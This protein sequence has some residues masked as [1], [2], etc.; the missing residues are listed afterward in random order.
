MPTLS[1]FCQVPAT[2]LLVALLLASGGIGGGP[3]VAQDSATS[4]P[5]AGA[6]EERPEVLARSRDW[7]IRRVAATQ[8]NPAKARERRALLRLL[9]EDEDSGVRIAALERLADPDIA[10]E[11]ALVERAAAVRLAAA[12]LMDRESDLM[13]LFGRETDPEVKGAIIGR[14]ATADTLATIYGRE[15][16]ARVRRAALERLLDLGLLNEALVRTVVRSD[17]DSEVRRWMLGHLRDP[18]LILETAL[19]DERAAVRERAVTRL[20]ETAPTP[21]RAIDQALEDISE[22][23][24]DPAVRVVALRALPEANDRLLEVVA[25]SHDERLRALIVPH[26]VDLDL[27][28]QLA[29]RDPAASVRRAALARVKDREVLLAAA[30]GDPDAAARRVAVR[31]L[32][33]DTDRA[34]VARRTGDLGVRTEAVSAITSEAVLEALALPEHYWHL[35]M[36]AATRITSPTVL[37]RLATEDPDRDVRLAATRRIKAQPVLAQI[38]RISDDDLRHDDEVIEAA[39]AGLEDPDLLFDF[40]RGPF[41]IAH[42]LQAVHLLSDTERL[43]SLAKSGLELPELRAAVHARL[44]ALGETKHAE[45]STEASVGAQLPADAG[46]LRALV[47]SSR[48]VAERV[49]AAKRLPRAPSGE[50][51]PEWLLAWI[52]GDDSAEVRAALVAR[53]RSPRIIEDLARQASSDQV[54]AA[55][56]EQVSAPRVLAELAERAEAEL[57]EGDS[58]R[59]VRRA[60]VARLS[61]TETL[62]RWAQKDP[63]QSVRRTALRRLVD[64]SPDRDLFRELARSDSDPVIREEAVRALSDAELL[65][66]I[67]RTDTDPLVAWR[68]G[69]AVERYG[70][71]TERESL[72]RA[73]GW[74]DE[75]ARQVA[76]GAL[77]PRLLALRHALADSGLAETPLAAVAV[78]A[79]SWLKTFKYVDPA[80]SYERPAPGLMVDEER[81]EVHL[82]DGSGRRLVRVKLRGER[83]TRVKRRDD[84]LPDGELRRLL[85]LADL[86][87]VALLRELVVALELDSAT[88]VKVKESSDPRLRAGAQSLLP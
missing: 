77:D 4:S 38:A 50:S 43:S 81:L 48:P 46:R 82:R 63:D 54:R 69:R 7:K 61:S 78:D 64:L 35:R 65:L 40:V 67:A 36:L 37:A 58:G 86:D 25:E 87:V 27:V 44:V 56:I 8:L 2:A 41:W 85:R 59:R 52:E 68:A 51:D 73:G 5:A 18:G 75:R 79:H 31:A 9:E 66:V 70:S 24:S 12:G 84:I 19:H 39:L 62:S 49:A 16:D 60:L 21:S 45:E 32:R 15:G 10:L 57:S 13:R 28:A 88:L 6:R 14:L 74:S 3:L 17:P 30:L 20:R 1:A 83:S 71:P 34:H 72:H 23:D 29:R 53:V 55:A 42:R 80:A 26:L 76:G 11:R 22:S 47:T 33:D